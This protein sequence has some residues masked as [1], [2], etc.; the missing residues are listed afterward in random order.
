MSDFQD[1]P[2][3]AIKQRRQGVRMSALELLHEF[4]IRHLW[5]SDKANAAGG[6]CRVRDNGLVMHAPFNPFPEAH[7]S[8]EARGLVHY[9]VPVRLSVC[10]TA[11]KI[12][13]LGSAAS[14][15]LRRF[16]RTDKAGA[17]LQGLSSRHY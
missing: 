5:Y 8:P 13:N 2:V 9:N 7:P 14:E 12:F 10:T 16:F 3:K 6:S 1:K 11:Q 17:L 4:F 15:V